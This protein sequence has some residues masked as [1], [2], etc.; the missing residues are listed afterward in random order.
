[1]RPPRP[2]GI[3][4]RRGMPAA[5]IADPAPFAAGRT[6]RPR[7]NGRGEEGR[8]R[9]SLPRPCQWMPGDHGPSSGGGSGPSQPPLAPAPI[10]A[11]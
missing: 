10:T 4:V 6:A 11:R 2:C 8:E 3:G 1:M 9:A 5:G 7:S